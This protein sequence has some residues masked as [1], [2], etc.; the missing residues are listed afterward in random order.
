MF[1]NVYGQRA[2]SYYCGIFLLIC[3]AY[4]VT[5]YSVVKTPAFS[6]VPCNGL[7][8]YN[9]GSTVNLLAGEFQPKFQI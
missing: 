9:N 6:Q 2:T 8:F 5:F 3:V 4:H 1:L 7:M